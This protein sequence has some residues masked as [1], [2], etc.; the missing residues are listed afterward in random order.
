[1][2]MLNKINPTLDSPLMTE[3]FE[4]E[5]MRYE[6]TSG[7]TPK[8]LF[9][10][11]KEVMHLLESLASA[12]IEGNRTT[13]VA[14]AN[15]AVNNNQRT[16]N[17]GILE[18]RNVRNAINY[19]ERVI[20]P[21]GAISLKNI[22][23]IH[24]RVVFNLNRDGSNNPG[25]FRQKEVTISG[26]S[27]VLPTFDN[28]PRLM[29]DLVDYINANNSKKEDI[30]KIA[31]VHHEFTVIHPFDNGNGRTARALT[32]AMLIKQGFLR[33]GKA[34]LNPSSVFCI[35]RKA[36]YDGLSRADAGTVE[37]LENWCLYVAKGI[38]EELNR[39]KKLLD[40]DYAMNNLI[41]PAI[42]LA[43]KQ[44]LITD[45]E[46]EIL[47]IAAEKDIIQAQDIAHLFGNT[48][49]NN[50][51]RSRFLSTMVNKGLLMRPPKSPKKYT[52][53]FM[54]KYLLTSILDIMNT[55]GLLPVHDSEDGLRGKTT[56]QSR[57]SIP[58]EP[59]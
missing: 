56:E 44:F 11:L 52:M 30:I 40:K 54:N 10:D 57:N 43:Q 2:N 36:Y 17:E 53:R 27:C 25:I 23:E 29:G 42:K 47:Q 39:V 5:R 41:L 13:L 28:V 51:K 19:I 37:G 1:M 49:S 21:G 38:S 32:Y 6:L 26:S 31:D 15:D 55:N 20:T 46:A 3:L 18:I 48:P 16:A 4:L 59:I 22:E 50:T 24:R 35:D 58:S 34:I 45:V 7:T 12:R 14:A 9:Y 33:N 8:W